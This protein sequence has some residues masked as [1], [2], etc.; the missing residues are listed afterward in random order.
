MRR[1][2]VKANTKVQRALKAGEKG[3]KA[4]EKMQRGA[5]AGEK[6]CKGW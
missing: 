2:V 6:G 1:G 4:S 3:T 5:K